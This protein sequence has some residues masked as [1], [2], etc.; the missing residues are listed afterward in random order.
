MRSGDAEIFGP[1]GS[2]RIAAG[3]T[4]LVRGSP[5]DP[6]F[7]EQ[8][9][10]GRDQFDDWNHTRDSQLLG[11]RSYQYVASDVYGAEDLDGY[12]RGY[13]LSMEPSGNPG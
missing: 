3:T 6:E 1:A 13:P 10:I 8:A 2:Q 9:A 11:S 12:G 4:M 7:Q 5:S